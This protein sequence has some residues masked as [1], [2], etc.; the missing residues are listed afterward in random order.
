MVQARVASGEVHPTAPMVGK[1]GLAAQG[2][3]GELE[4]GVLSQFPKEIEALC[5]EGL[6]AVRRATRLPVQALSWTLEDKVLKLVFRLPSGAFATSV[7]AELLNT[8]LP[9]RTATTTE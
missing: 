3:A 1:G 9:E 6:D 7:L 4:A 2:E 8:R 5:E